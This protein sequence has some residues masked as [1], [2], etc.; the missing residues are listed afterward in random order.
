[1]SKRIAYPIMSNIINNSQLKGSKIIKLWAIVKLN[2][3]EPYGDLAARNLKSILGQ[4]TASELFYLCN[5]CMGN[6]L[7]AEKQLLKLIPEYSRKEAKKYNLLNE[8]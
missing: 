3:N 8:S 2:R 4:E 1:M 6:S 7:L 5:Y